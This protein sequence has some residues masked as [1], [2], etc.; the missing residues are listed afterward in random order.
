MFRNRPCPLIQSIRCIRLAFSLGDF[1][2][3]QHFASSFAQSFH[4]ANSRTISCR[5][6]ANACLTP[7]IDCHNRIDIATQ[8]DH[9]AN[10][11]APK[12]EA[13][14]NAVFLIQPKQPPLHISV[15]VNYQKHAETEALSMHQAANASSMNGRLIS[16]SAN[17]ADGVPMADAP[18]ASLTRSPA[19]MASS[20]LP[21]VAVA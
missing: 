7:C 10:R 11:Q 6:I 17:P 13:C 8:C 14:R 19:T 18:L 1:Q 12:S 4:Y 5:R 2:T 9:R 16:I 3:R 20:T 15:S 21:A